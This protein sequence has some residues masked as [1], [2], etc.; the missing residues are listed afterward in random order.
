MRMSYN[1]D[2]TYRLKQSKSPQSV[3]KLGLQLLINFSVNR[4]IYEM[5]LQNQ[6]W[7]L[8]EFHFGLQK[9]ENVFFLKMTENES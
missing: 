8:T 7:R 3:I 5:I 9:Q 4:L 1:A 6:R 2:T